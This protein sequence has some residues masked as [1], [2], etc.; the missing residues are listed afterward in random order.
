MTTT[1]PL[2]V[3][4]DTQAACIVFAAAVATFVG[5][6][7]FS[8]MFLMGAVSIEQPKILE[9]VIGLVMVDV[10]DDFTSFKRTAQMLRHHIAVLQH[11][12]IRI[13]HRL[14]FPN[15]EFYI[16]RIMCRSAA[17]PIATVL[18]RI[19]LFIEGAIAIVG[20]KH[21][22]TSRVNASRNL[23]AAFRTIHATNVTAVLRI[24]P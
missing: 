13:S 18:S 5:Y 3:V 15:A 2:H 17:L 23:G 19:R 24:H 22:A 1:V 16:A 9:S 20:A 6:S 21:I 12:A 11:I 10:V 7:C 8:M 14:T 4:I